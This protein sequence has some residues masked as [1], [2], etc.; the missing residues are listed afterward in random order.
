MKEYI[1]TLDTIKRMAGDLLSL[2]WN[3]V[4]PA[5]DGS[6]YKYITSPDEV[7][8]NP[9]QKPTGVSVKEFFFPK[10][11]PLFYYKKNNGDVKV[12]DPQLPERKTLIL[13]A[14]PCD[15]AGIPVLSKVFNW[16]YQ[17]NFFN[18]RVKN[19][20]VIGLGCN[21]SDPSCFCTSVGLSQTAVKGSDLFLLPL[22]NGRF[23]LQVVTEKGEEFLKAIKEFGEENKTEKAPSSANSPEKKFEYDKVK[24]WLDEN[25]QSDFW[26]NKGEL[27]LGCAQC[28]FVCPTCHCFDIV[29]ESCGYECGKRVKNW[30][31]CQFGLFTKHASGHNPRDDQGKRYRQ[32]VNHKF[33]YYNDKFSEILCTGCGRCSR[34]CAAGIDIGDIMA[35]INAL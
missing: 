24:K 26:D 3:V 6:K 4:S 5:A 1:I 35:E 31:A 12:I 33:K 28:A 21:Y 9:N 16:D 18:T 14:K 17:D 20:L 10:T 29:D 27:C 2:G 25:F 15:A 7:N 8:L 34:G 23:I 19:S 22:E 30:D 13:G 11:E 32:R